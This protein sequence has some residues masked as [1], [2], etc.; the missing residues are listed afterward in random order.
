MGFYMILSKT[1]YI[2]IEP[3]FYVNKIYRIRTMNHVLVEPPAACKNGQSRTNILSLC[4]ETFTGSQI[5]SLLNLNENEYTISS[6]EFNRL[7]EEIRVVIYVLKSL[8]S[9]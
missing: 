1:K 7:W 3:R 5:S 6:D 4:H 2:G 8:E 9:L